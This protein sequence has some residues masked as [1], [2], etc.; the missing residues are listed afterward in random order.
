MIDDD[1]GWTLQ[2]SGD[3]HSTQDSFVLRLPNLII[4]NRLKRMGDSL[5]ASKI[6]A[7]KQICSFMSGKS[8]LDKISTKE[9]FREL[10]MLSIK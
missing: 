7:S 6:S 1:Q 3:K 9:I 4:K 5:Y 10:N 2:I 8:L